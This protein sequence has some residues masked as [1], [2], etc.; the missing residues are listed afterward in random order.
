MFAS[1]LLE[2]IAGLYKDQVRFWVWRVPHRVLHVLGVKPVHLLVPYSDILLFIKED[3]A[4]NRLNVDSPDSLW[5]C[6][7]W[8]WPL[9]PLAAV[10]L[11]WPVGESV[12]HTCPFPFP[13]S[14]L[15]PSAPSQNSGLLLL[16]F[17]PGHVG[18]LSAQSP[19]L[20]DSQQE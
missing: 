16:R 1:E 3:R 19:G 18:A 15:A 20:P 2:A 13:F 9:R 7:G 5:V 4:S 10:D 8:P 17:E 11:S 12:P 6:E 14:R